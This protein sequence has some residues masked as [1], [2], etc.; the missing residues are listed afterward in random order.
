MTAFED[1]TLMLPYSVI[2]GFPSQPL[3]LVFSYIHIRIHRSP[4]RLIRGSAFLLDLGCCRLAIAVVT[5]SVAFCRFCA[6]EG[7][8]WDPFHLELADVWDLVCRVDELE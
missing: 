1:A 7:I 6:T 3:I 4:D 2:S 8:V 5:S